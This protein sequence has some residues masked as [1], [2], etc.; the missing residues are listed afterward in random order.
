MVQ[1]QP[2]KKRHDPFIGTVGVIDN[3][4]DRKVIRQPSGGISDLMVMLVSTPSCASKITSQLFL[5]AVSPPFEPLGRRRPSRGG[6]CERR[7]CHAHP[8]DTQESEHIAHVAR[9]FIAP[10]EDLVSS[11]DLHLKQRRSEELNLLF[12]RDCKWAVRRSAF[13]RPPQIFHLRLRIVIREVR[14]VVGVDAMATVE[15]I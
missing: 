14:V 1:Q 9:I 4:D 3:E 12:N 5:T 15:K 2:L 6:N 13:K 11:A 7:N 8:N 10:I